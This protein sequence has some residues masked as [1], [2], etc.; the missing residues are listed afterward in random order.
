MC[1]HRLGSA[2]LCLFGSRGEQSSAKVDD[3]DL[4]QLVGWW[5]QQL[6]REME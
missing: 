2:L 1:A 5:I 6:Q 3:K 4:S